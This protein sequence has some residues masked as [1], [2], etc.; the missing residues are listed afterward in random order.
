MR[1]LLLLTLLIVTTAVAADPRDPEI[2]QAQ[3]R[4]GKCWEAHAKDRTCMEGLLT[5]D[6]NAVMINGRPVD[7][8]GFIEIVHRLP[9]TNT[10]RNE[11]GEH[12]PSDASVRF[13]GNT[14]VVTYGVAHKAPV[15][16][17]DQFTHVYVKTDAGWQMV[18][19]H[20]SHPNV[21]GQS[22]K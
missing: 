6:F 2:R 17:V 10:W 13:Y 18:R 8:A 19:L 1:P 4:F 20:G 11:K 9:E 16:H 5:S 12:L 7:K 21:S 14:A 15:E 3:E 22:K